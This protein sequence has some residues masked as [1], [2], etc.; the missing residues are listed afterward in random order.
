MSLEDCETKREAKED[1]KIWP[2]LEKVHWRQKSGE[3]WAREGERNVGFFQHMAHPHF[4]INS[5]TRINING[6][7]LSNERE[8]RAGISSTFQGD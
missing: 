2:P 5:M 1:F 3:T 4:Q 6:V 7:W 8:I